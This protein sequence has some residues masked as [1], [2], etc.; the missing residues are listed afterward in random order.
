MIPSNSSRKGCTAA[1]GKRT[2][3]EDYGV[4]ITD[5]LNQPAEILRRHARPQHASSFRKWACYAA[6]YVIRNLRKAQ[7]I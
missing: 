5:F 7:G 3:A 1:G 2:R 6:A 4:L